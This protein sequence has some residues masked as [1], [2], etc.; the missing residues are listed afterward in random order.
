MAHA[1]SDDLDDSDQ[2]KALL[3]AVMKTAIDA[4]VTIDD[5]GVFSKLTMRSRSCLG[6]PSKK[7]S[8]RIY[9][10]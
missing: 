3:I 4:I 10:F 1:Q 7:L 8:G 5:Q 6:I 9:P 2:N